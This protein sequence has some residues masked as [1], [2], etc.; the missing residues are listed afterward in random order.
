M[1]VIVRTCEFISVRDLYQVSRTIREK[2]QCYHKHWIVFG[3]GWVFLRKSVKEICRSF[4]SCGIRWTYARERICEKGYCYPFSGRPVSMAGSV[5]RKRLLLLSF[6]YN[7]GK[8][9]WYKSPFSQSCSSCTGNNVAVTQQ[10]GRGNITD[11]YLS[12]PCQLPAFI[13]TVM[14]VK[15]CSDTMLL[16]TRPLTGWIWSFFSVCK[17]WTLK[18]VCLYV[19]QKTQQTDSG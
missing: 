19:Q 3:C 12:L 5:V 2:V 17:S 1:H 11:V 8:L 13:P 16:S 15:Y 18:D 9:T 4:Y 14:F 6:S 7:S 10:Q